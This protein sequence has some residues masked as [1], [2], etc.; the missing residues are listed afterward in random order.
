MQRAPLINS[1][2]PEPRKAP[3]HATRLHSVQ[4][5]C[6]RLLPVII[7]RFR[8]SA[9]PYAQAAAPLL[10]N[11]FEIGIAFA[12]A[13]TA[14]HLKTVDLVDPQIQRHTDR[15]VAV[16]GRVEGNQRATQRQLQR[17]RVTQSAVEDRLAVFAFANL[18]VRSVL[19]RGDEAALRIEVIERR[20]TSPWICPPSKIEQPSSM[21]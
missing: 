7:R 1:A 17:R 3:A 21:P 14:R 8:Q 10:T 12:Y 16:D 15:Q 2:Q 6:Q 4:Q 13:Q 18:E 5:T 19:G 9:E 20:G 11:P